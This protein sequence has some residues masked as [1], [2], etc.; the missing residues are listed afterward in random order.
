M[1]SAQRTEPPTSYP[2][3]I[4]SPSSHGY[5]QT[6]GLH[7]NEAARTCFYND[8]EAEVKEGAA[9]RQDKPRAT[10][11][12][13]I[14]PDHFPRPAPNHSFACWQR[15]KTALWRFQPRL[16]GAGGQRSSRCIRTRVTSGWVGDLVGRRAI[17]TRR[18]VVIGSRSG[19]TSKHTYAAYLPCLRS[20]SCTAHACLDMTIMK[21]CQPDTQHKI[22]LR[23][24]SG[25][26]LAVYQCTHAVS[27]MRA[28][29]LSSHGFWSLCGAECDTQFFGSAYECCVA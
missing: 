16:S 14:Y 18:L 9:A 29:P 3:P 6:H 26:E 22:S 4:I 19:H 12:A 25:N 27:G 11:F 2:K 5:L 15:N 20:R 21:G 28:A 24:I 7:V 8:M 1:D 13:Q 10:C 23:V 17:A